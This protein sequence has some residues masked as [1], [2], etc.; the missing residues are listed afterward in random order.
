[1]VDDLEQNQS[2]RPWNRKLAQEEFASVL[3]NHK[4]DKREKFI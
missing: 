2:V 4:Q 3:D 1:M